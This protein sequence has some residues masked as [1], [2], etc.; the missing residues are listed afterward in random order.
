MAWAALC[1]P[2]HAPPPPGCGAD[3][4][5]CMLHAPCSGPARPTQDPQPVVGGGAAAALCSAESLAGPPSAPLRPGPLGAC[6]SEDLTRSWDPQPWEEGRTPPG[7]HRLTNSSA[8]C[9][10][11]TVVSALCRQTADGTGGARVRWAWQR[12]ATAACLRL[13]PHV[14]LSSRP[15]S[16]FLP[17]L[18]FQRRSLTLSFLRGERRLSLPGGVLH[19]VNQGAITI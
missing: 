3:A 17:L 6:H 12:R 5:P 1:L 10:D 2:L 9:W 16:S 14:A 13:A 18:A 8:C 4:R 11:S 7:S 19:S 15:S